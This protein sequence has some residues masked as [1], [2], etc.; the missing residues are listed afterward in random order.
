MSLKAVIT[1]LLKWCPGFESAA[2]FKPDHKVDLRA[3]LFSNNRFFFMGLFLLLLSNVGSTV[4]AN[5]I[6]TIQPGEYMDYS[7]DVYPGQKLRVDAGVYTGDIS[8]ND[9]RVLEVLIMDDENFNHFKSEEYDKINDRIALSIGENFEETINLNANWF[10]KAHVVLNNKIRVNNRDTQ[11][12]THVTVTLLK[13]LG[14]L[15]LPGFLI[16]I[17]SGYKIIREN[18]R[19]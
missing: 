1:R 14:Y 12:E 3:V 16:V 19:Q 9:R 7:I 10:G 4:I 18:S 17:L 11:K 8:D 5:E 15:G 13:P 6:I 2:S